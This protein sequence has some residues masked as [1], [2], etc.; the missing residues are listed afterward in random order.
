MSSH[1][2]LY[3]CLAAGCVLS[4][5][6]GFGQCGP[7]PPGLGVSDAWA[8][9]QAVAVRVDSTTFS[10]SEYNSVIAA[11][12]N[13]SSA[14]GSGVGITFA[15]NYAPTTG[16]PPAGTFEV[17]KLPPTT[18]GAQAE[19]ITVSS[20]GRVSSAYAV[21]APQV[22]MEGGC[23][24]FWDTPI[25]VDTLGNGFDLTSAAA[26][27]MFDIDGDGTRER[28]SWTVE[29][30]DDAWLALDRNGNGRIDKRGRTVQQWHGATS[31]EQS[32]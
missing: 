21:I 28:V 6:S 8:P 32:T 3:V 26:G 30:S 16:S 13:W 9:N 4:S 24:L 20:G 11:F 27:V 17:A 31:V 1:R 2:L 25:I 14:L 7:N 22:Y 23:C 12:Q 19:V 10:A 29:N 18:A 5:R 15:F